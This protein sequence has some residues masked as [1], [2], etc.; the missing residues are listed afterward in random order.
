MKAHGVN[1]RQGRTEIGRQRE[2]G[3]FQDV[4]LVC[5]AIDMTFLPIDATG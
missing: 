2:V 1:I 5:P 4:A 3:S